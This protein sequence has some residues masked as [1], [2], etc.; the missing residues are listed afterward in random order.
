MVFHDVI[1]ECFEGTML[2]PCLLKPCLLCE[3]HNNRITSNITNFGIAVIA[4]IAA[5][6]L[7]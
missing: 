2:E 4:V 7:R 6:Q 5:L 3:S 1:C